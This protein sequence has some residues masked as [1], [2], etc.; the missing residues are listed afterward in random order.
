MISSRVFRGRLALLGVAQVMIELRV[1]RNA[2]MSAATSLSIGELCGSQSAVDVFLKHSKQRH[3]AW[4]VKPCYYITKCARDGYHIRVSSRGASP[5]ST[6]PLYTTSPRKAK[7]FTPSSKV[8]QVLPTPAELQ[9]PSI[10]LN[11]LAHQRGCLYCLHLQPS[12]PSVESLQPMSRLAV[13]S[14][15]GGKAR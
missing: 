9:G 13:A 5:P 3:Q 1:R 7:R 2:T 15:W 14:G 11:C 10:D 12:S 6:P 8:L 4:H